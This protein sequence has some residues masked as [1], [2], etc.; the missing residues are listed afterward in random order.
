MGSGTAKT[1]KGI[2]EIAGMIQRQFVE[3]KSL[4]DALVAICRAEL[5]AEPQ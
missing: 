1:G 4:L 2:G 3:P 5:P